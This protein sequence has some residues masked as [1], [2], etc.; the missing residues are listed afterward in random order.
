MP[1]TAGTPLDP[2]VTR[3]KVLTAATELFYVRGVHAVGVDE[4]V[5][6]AGVSK[7][8]LYRH[9]GSKDGLVAQVLATRSERIHAWLDTAVRRAADGTPRGRVLAVFDALCRWY[10]ETGFRGC[11][12]VNAAV[13]TRGDDTQ[14][15]AIARGHLARYQ[16]LFTTE[17]VAMGAREP[18]SLARQLLVLLEGATTVAAIEQS[19][20]AGHHA[21]HMA[22]V[23]LDA[24]QPVDRS[25]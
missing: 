5:R 21:R 14:A 16:E 13:D 1:V 4:I 10:A 3:D 18:V 17:L 12:I 9:F 24:D 6:A 23:L 11:A 8:S 19:P 20:E 2:A 22:E 25:T 15:P 7:L